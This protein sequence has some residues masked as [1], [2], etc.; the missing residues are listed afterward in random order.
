MKIKRIYSEQPEVEI[1][2]NLLKYTYPENIKKYFSKNHN[3]QPSDDLINI[4]SG[5]LSQAYEYFSLSRKSSLQVSPLL[6]YYG[7]TNLIHGT[8]CLVY[9]KLLKITNHGMKLRKL[10]GIDKIGDVTLNINDNK[11]GGLSIFINEYNPYKQEFSSNIEWS[12]EEIAGSIVELSNDFSDLYGQEN[13]HAIPIKEI[14]LDNEVQYRVNL[15]IF[16]ETQVTTLLKSIPDFSKSYF[17]FEKNRNNELI[18]RKKIHGQKLHEVTTMG[19]SFFL[20][21]IRK[22]V[23]KFLFHIF[24]YS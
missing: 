1:W 19:E 23:N 18:I 6:I 5:S 3:S 2:E 12:F 11:T 20:L 16:N 10:S 24:H 7:S 15:D 17:P 4:I 8:L 21:V 14:I 13:I 9:G 22:M